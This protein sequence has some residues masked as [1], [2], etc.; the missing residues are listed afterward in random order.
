MLCE[1]ETW[2]EKEEDV[3][4]LDKNDAS[5]VIKMCIVKPENIIIAEEFRVRLK[6]KGIRNRKKTAIWFGHLEKMEENAGIVNIK[7][8]WLVVGS[9]FHKQLS[10]P[11]KHFSSF[12]F[13]L[14]FRKGVYFSY[15]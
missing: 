11:Y 2:P 7:F 15:I 14:T 9:I 5:M 6:L 10:N 13:S 4:V 8:S 1:I 12:S 3:S